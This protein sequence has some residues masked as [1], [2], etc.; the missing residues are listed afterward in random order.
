MNSLKHLMVRYSV[1]GNAHSLC[2]CLKV[3]YYQDQ[4]YRFSVIN[5]GSNPSKVE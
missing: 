4:G 3:P 5:K 2:D 1:S